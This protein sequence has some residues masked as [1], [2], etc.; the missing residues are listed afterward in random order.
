MINY[1]RLAYRGQFLLFPKGE[2][3]TQV[4]PSRCV[5][6]GAV[7]PAD[8]PAVEQGELGAVERPTV[9]ATPGSPDGPVFERRA[10]PPVSDTGAV[11]PATTAVE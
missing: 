7:R 3:P 2:G 8:A 10:R 6:Y 4:A 11:R 1:R 9:V 5:T